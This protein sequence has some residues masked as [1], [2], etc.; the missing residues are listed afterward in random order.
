MDRKPPRDAQPRPGRRAALRG[1]ATATAFFG[2]AGLRNAVAQDGTLRVGLV[3]FPPNMRPLENTGSSQAAIKLMIN[4]G[5]LAYDAGGNLVPELAQEFA[6]DGPDA[7]RFA[8]RGN[9]KFHN[10]EPVTA[11]DVKYSFEQIT[12]ANSSA[13]LRSYFAV[14][15]RVEVTGPLTG[16]YVLKEPSTPFPHLLASYH[17]P[18]LSQKSPTGANALPISAGPFRMGTIER[19]SSIEVERFDGFYKPGRPR[20]ARIR[21]QAYGDDNL[22]VSA[23]Q[24]GDVD[25]IEGVPWQAMDSIEANPR[26]RLDSTVGPFMNVV[27]N[28]QAGPFTNPKLRQAVAWAVNRQDVIRAALYGRG[29]PLSGLPMPE[30]YA[31]SSFADPFK[32]DPARAKQLMAEAGVPNGFSC[33]L[34]S[35]S[36]P[37]VHQQT[38]EVLQ[39]NLR[40]VGIDAQLRLHDWTTRVAMGNRGQYDLAIMGSVINWPDPDSLSLF[41]DG[42]AS[43]SR[44][45][46]FK[47]ERMN[48][49]F[50]A[51]RRESDP[52]KRRAIYDDLQRVAAEECPIV[53]LALRAQAFGVQAGV[54]GFRNFPGSLTF[55]APISLEEA[56]LG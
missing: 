44:S 52:A 3:N 47:S 53:W 9:A 25:I 27:F 19:G 32:L 6:A 46:G 15:D 48:A 49:I 20:A 16:R 8:L 21:F 10:G 14:V 4:R 33:Q 1:A 38:A 22:R 42:P 56:A 30:A 54:K 31:R 35:T 13:F 45:F 40:E 28:T 29:T 24:A 2:A 34:L 26:L 55:Y 5:L 7:Y 36:S 11:E 51:G 18:V 50:A 23:L 39:Q 41:L 37:L 17:A 43:Y 12:A